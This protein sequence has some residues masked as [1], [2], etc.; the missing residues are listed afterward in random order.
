MADVRTNQTGN[1][2]L[3]DEAGTAVTITSGRLSVLPRGAAVSGV[4]ATITNTT[5]T[6]VYTPTSG[7]A[8]RLKWIGLKTPAGAAD[9]VVTIRIGATT[10]YQWPMTALDVFSHST[11]REGAADAVLSVQCSVASTVYVNID[12]EEF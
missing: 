12:V 7:K 8:V 11:I 3:Y 6:T 4:P 1:V 9:T 5:Q 2:T 10:I